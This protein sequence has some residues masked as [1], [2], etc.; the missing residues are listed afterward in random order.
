MRNKKS[1][2]MPPYVINMITVGE[3]GGQLEKV[4]L[5][6][7]SSYEAQTDKAVQLFMTLLEPILILVMGLVVGFIVVA[8][9]LPIFQFNIMIR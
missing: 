2:F 9:L 7:A 8:M 3:E 5:R 1:A 6:I 4:L